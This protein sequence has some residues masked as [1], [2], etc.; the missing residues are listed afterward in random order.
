MKI[1]YLIEPTNVTNTGNISGKSLRTYEVEVTNNTGKWGQLKI[2]STGK[3]YFIKDG[4]FICKKTK[5]R[6]NDKWIGYKLD[7]KYT[8]DSDIHSYGSTLFSSP[9]IAL[10]AKAMTITN[11]INNK[12]KEFTR[13]I[14]SLEK[15]KEKLPDISFI[16]ENHP[17]LFV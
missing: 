10:A 13:N 14:N 16:K 11:I 5:A 2:R 3:V 17:E 7:I 9:E 15:A 1:A 12:L 4:E 6:L 8:I